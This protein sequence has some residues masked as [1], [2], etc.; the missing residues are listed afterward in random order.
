MPGIDDK[1]FATLS[2]SD[3]HQY[4]QDTDSDY[5]QLKP[6]DQQAYLGHVTGRQGAAIP[7]SIPRPD[8]IRDALAKDPGLGES[9]LPGVSEGAGLREGLNEYS[10]QSIGQVGAGLKDIGQGNITK[11]AH[12]TL[13]GGMNAL[14]P[15]AGFVPMGTLARGAVGGMLGSKTASGT[16]GLMGGGEDAQ[17]LAG[18]VGGIAGGY[19]A[20]RNVPM[21]GRLSRMIDVTKQ[22]AH[23]PF[24][25]R[26]QRYANAWKEP[27]LREGAPLP[28]NPE[29]IGEGAANLRGL[30]ARGAAQSP[31]AVNKMTGGPPASPDAIHG[32]LAN[33]KGRM[34][35]TPAEVQATEHMQKL[36]T[37]RA[38]QNGMQYAAG[39]R[40]AAGKVPRYPT[41]TI[42]EP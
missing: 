13:S 38:R 39:M 31:F 26:V 11:G 41:P 29:S 22:E 12:E 15:A 33:P 36:A 23:I 19:G 9:Q 28:A 25:G 5:Q 17:D 32:T 40:P 16:V 10:K 18:D 35:L 34:V 27:V 8:P 24:L 6:E 3:Q 37:I 1:D 21:N 20:T 14:T 42:E 7:P 2:P 30:K 4:L